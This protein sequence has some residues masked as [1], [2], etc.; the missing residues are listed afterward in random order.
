M[1]L[2]SRLD[3]KVVALAQLYV[4]IYR[5]TVLACANMPYIR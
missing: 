2:S 1:T 4:F 5:W 3:L